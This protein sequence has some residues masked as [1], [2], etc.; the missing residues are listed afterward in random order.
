MTMTTIE[1][2]A[3][4]YRL[5]EEGHSFSDMGKVLGVGADRARQ[6]YNQAVMA[7]QPNPWHPLPPPPPPTKEEQIA[8]A[9]ERRDTWELYE[10]GVISARA[11]RAIGLLCTDEYELITREDLEALRS[12]GPKTV[13]EVLDFVDRYY[14]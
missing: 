5:R 3:K 14:R 8:K 9:I 13:Q 11:Q 4:A 6:I 12:I 10:L 7:M 2:L 1:R